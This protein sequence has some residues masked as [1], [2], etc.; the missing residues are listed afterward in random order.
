MT[1]CLKKSCSFWFT[2]HILRGC[3]SVCECTSFPFGFKRGMWG[4]IVLVLGDCL[5]FLLSCM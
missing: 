4:L 1:T 5:S 3:L 2:K